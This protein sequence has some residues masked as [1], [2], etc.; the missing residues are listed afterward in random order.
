MTFRN[1]EKG[2]GF[3]VPAGRGDDLFVRV[4]ASSSVGAELMAEMG[5]ASGLAATARP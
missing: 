2:Y 5:D 1:V 3:I 4:T